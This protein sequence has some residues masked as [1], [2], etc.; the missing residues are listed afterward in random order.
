MR[1]KDKVAIITGAAGGM[2]RRTVERFLEEGGLVAAVD[3]SSDALGVLGE[4]E[5]ILKIEADI[6]K[7]EDVNGVVERAVRHYGRV[8]TLVN[9][10]GI[11][12]SATA[13]EEV[14]V[15]MWDRLLSVNTKSLFLT[16]KAVVPTM[17]KQGKGAIINIAS[18]SAV[19]PRPGLNAYITS[20]GAALAF[21]QALAIELAAY[22]IRV[23]AINPG[24]ADTGMLAQF[25]AKD[26]DVDEAKETIFKKSVPLGELIHPNDIANA[27]VYLAS[28][29]ASKVTGAIFNI[30]GGRGL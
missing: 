6:T 20:K 5:R 18:I 14:T 27:I 25:V 16:S 21:T 23:N 29:E 24:P 12:Q 3:L 15:E 8:D 22:N 19:R 30:D 9:I 13:I 2:G 7:E 11:A 17:K 1:L 10:A 26:V 4:D 28:E